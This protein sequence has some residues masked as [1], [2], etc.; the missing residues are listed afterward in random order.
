MFRKV[1]TLGRLHIPKK[2]STRLG[3]VECDSVEITIEYGKICIKKFQENID[4][5]AMPYI[6]IVRNVSLVNRVV[7]PKDYLYTL[8]ITP[9]TDLDLV[10][11]GNVLRIS[12]V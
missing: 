3:L 12:K 7:I 1:D 11:D 5:N 6:G 9:N 2:I 10:L 8:K 4:I